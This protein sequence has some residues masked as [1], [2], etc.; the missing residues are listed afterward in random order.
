MAKSLQALFDKAV[1]LKNRGRLTDAIAIYRTAVRQYPQSGAA[2]HNLA[3]ALGD[4]GRAGEAETHIRR[5]FKKGLDAP[6]SWLVYARALFSQGDADEARDAYEKVLDKN[7]AII[8]AQLELAQLI[9]MTTGDTESA[10]KRLEAT[11][12]AYP[13]VPV[14]HHVKAT[15]LRFTE[16]QASTLDFVLSSLERWP[17]DATLL[18]RAVDAGV[19]C[20]EFDAALEY[21]ERL[22]EVQPDTS[23]AFETRAL[24]LLAAGRA[25]EALEVAERLVSMFPH[26]Q[27][28]IA[29]LATSCRLVGDERYEQLFD[30]E[31]LVRRYEMATPKGWSSLNEFLD[32]LRNDLSSRHQYKKHP[33]MNS[34]VGGSMIMDFA[35]FD[36]DATRSLVHSLTPPIDAHVKHLG[37]GTDIVRSRNTGR[38]E[39][40]GIWSVLLRP[41]GFHHDHVHP[42]GWLSSACYI[43]LPDTLGANGNE[44]WIKF[45]E[46]GVVTTPGLSWEH[47]IEPRIGTIVLFPSYMWHGTIPFGGERQ[48]MTCA[49]DVI[50]K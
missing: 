24:A 28:A 8:D 27:H 34:L 14:L 3:A 5:A 11:I 38:W 39:I 20:G 4:A 40:G 1:D 25:A 37:K 19:H 50:P 16:G 17:D 47:A 6:E 42:K 12:D 44:G 10:L 26:D 23:Q 49:L 41:D 36:S 45:G 13:T 32:D 15:V 9:W 35:G 29:L 18:A 48:R 30:Y 46:P 2:E 21:S 33:F 7:P 31:N 22:A 43:D